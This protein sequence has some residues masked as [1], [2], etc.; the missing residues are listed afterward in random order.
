MSKLVELKQDGD[1][2]KLLE[3]NKTKLVVVDFFATWCGP[4]KTIAPLFKE[5]SEKYDAVFVK[6]DVDKLEETAKS[7]NVSAMPT[8]IALKN[9]EKVG[10]VVGAS[11]A[12]V[13]DMIKKHI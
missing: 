4:C 1:L 5:L 6:V 10:E 7:H 2:E 9:G 13:E 11:I 3:E 8:F 12:K